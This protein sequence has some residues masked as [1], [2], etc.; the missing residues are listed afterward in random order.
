MFTKMDIHFAYTS[1]AFY[2][3]IF[4]CIF[5]SSEAYQAYCLSHPERN[6]ICSFGWN[7]CCSLSPIHMLCTVYQIIRKT[8]FRFSPQYLFF[9]LVSFITSHCSFGWNPCCSLSPIHM[10]CTV[11]QI[12]R[13]TPFRFSPQY[14][15]F[16]LVSFITSHIFLQ[17]FHKNSSVIVVSFMTSFPLKSGSHFCKL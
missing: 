14:L 8:P 12:I 2:P 10:L 15:F 9:L 4:C 5:S 1:L 13:K 16:L 3:A 17:P 6:S 11:Y 7:P